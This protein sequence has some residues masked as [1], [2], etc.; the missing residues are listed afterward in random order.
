MPAGPVR[1]GASLSQR[2]RQL[3]SD[4]LLGWSTVGDQNC[5]VRQIRDMKGGIGATTLRPSALSGYCGHG[6]T[7]GKAVADFATAAA[8]QNEQDHADL[9]TAMDKGPLAGQ[10]TENA[11]NAGSG[12][13]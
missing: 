12:R 1:G 3:S 4:R 5:Y 2:H 6:H 11:G 8:D 10:S 7:L 9:R 13:R